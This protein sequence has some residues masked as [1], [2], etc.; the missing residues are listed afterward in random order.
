MGV[1]LRLHPGRWPQGGG[2]SAVCPGGRCWVRPLGW[3]KRGAGIDV[4]GAGRVMPM[5][6]R[7]IADT[8]SVVRLQGGRAF[9]RGRMRAGWGGSRPGVSLSIGGRT[10]AVRLSGGRPEAG[11]WSEAA[12]EGHLSR[13]PQRGGGAALGSD[14]KQEGVQRAGGRSGGAAAGKRL[15]LRRRHVG[16]RRGAGGLRGVAQV[17]ADRRAA[18]QQG[19]RRQRGSGVRPR[20]RTQ[21]RRRPGRSVSAN[22][23]S[24]SLPNTTE[25][26]R[27]AALGGARAV[28][29]SGN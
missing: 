10:S 26:E 14:A 28:G 9:G 7:A 22:P 18:T 8:P 20:T 12:G 6:I 29:L 5:W 23:F 19:R 27:G 17:P 4:V 16:R 21:H 11:F 25:V 2:R 15:R 24:A 3:M 13:R 1:C